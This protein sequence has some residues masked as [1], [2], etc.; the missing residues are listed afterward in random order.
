M[1]VLIAG[2]T[3]AVGSRL[4]PLLVA[5]GRKV[6]GPARSPAKAEIA[7][8]GRRHS[9]RRRRLRQGGG[10]SRGARGG[11]RG[12]RAASVRSWL[13]VEKTRSKCTRSPASV[14][15]VS[16]SL[17]H[18]IA[19]AEASGTRRFIAQ[20]FCGWPLAR[21]GARVKTEEA[22]LDFRAAA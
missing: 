11:P 20:S 21:T 15:D 10:Q 14:S 13:V 12:R 18:L 1:R 6:T 4:V 5:A 7:Q 2:A 17:D 8:P 22:P 9:G 16:S 3:G 19:A